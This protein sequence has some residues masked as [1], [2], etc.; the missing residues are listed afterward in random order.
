MVCVYIIQSKI[1]PER[2][3]VGSSINFRRR[4][5][6]HLCELKANK[7]HSGKLQNHVNK[8]GIDD[9]E[10][11]LLDKCSVQ[12]I[13]AVEQHF[14]NFFKPYFNILPN[15]YT[16]LGHKVSDETK[17]KHRLF[18]HTKET[19]KRLRDNFTPEK[20]ELY[21]KMLTGEN[22]PNYGRIFGEET[23]TK[24]RLK[25][26]NKKQSQELI[27][28]RV[29]TL[30]IPIKCLNNNTVYWNLQCFYSFIN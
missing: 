5:T 25:K 8:Y 11:S 21:S 24:Q 28:K 20:R 22:H 10:W 17:Q 4:K 23:R 19:I 30:K 18:R 12:D 3:Y 6:K 26:L 7:H 16:F 14:M 2:V 29:E 1:K 27:D 9:L 13:T 15:A